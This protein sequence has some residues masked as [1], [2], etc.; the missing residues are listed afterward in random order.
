MAIQSKQTL[1]VIASFLLS[2]SF[3]MFLICIKQIINPTKD[4]ERKDIFD[5]MAFHNFLSAL[6][7]KKWLKLLCFSSFFLLFVC[8]KV[9]FF[10]P[11]LAPINASLNDL[12]TNKAK[13]GDFYFFP[14]LSWNFFMVQSFS[15]F[16]FTFRQLLMRK[17][18]HF[19]FFSC[20]HVVW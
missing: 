10:L 20:V 5:L 2:F 13:H 11:H 19:N 17:S 9:C 8:H 14:R 1:T 15:F 4:N 7:D 16:S 6:T 12:F 3:F 18:Q